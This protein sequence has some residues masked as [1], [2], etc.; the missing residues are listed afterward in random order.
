MKLYIRIFKPFKH[1]FSLYLYKIKL[2][3]HIDMLAIAGKTAGPNWLTFFWKTVGTL[4]VTR[5]KRFFQNRFFSSKFE[6]LTSPLLPQYGG[7]LW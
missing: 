6:F 4:G 2:F 7:M 5:L 3:A 1:I